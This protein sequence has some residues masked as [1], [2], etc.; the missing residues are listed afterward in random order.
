MLYREREA[1]IGDSLAHDLSHVNAHKAPELL[2]EG[3]PQFAVDVYAFGIISKY[4]I[5]VDLHFLKV[6]V[7]FK[8][9]YKFHKCST[10]HGAN[11]IFA[12]SYLCAARVY[13]MHCLVACRNI[14]H[15]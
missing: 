10:A 6:C 8:Y 5:W 3:K 14:E 1:A 2:T 15:C 9:I 4:F 11:E 7:C 12:L 13:C